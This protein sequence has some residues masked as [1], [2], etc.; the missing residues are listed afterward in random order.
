M[1]LLFK[2]T[3]KK[4]SIKTFFFPNWKNIF[5]QSKEIISI[6]KRFQQKKAVLI[7]VKFVH[8]SEIFGW[9]WN[10]WLML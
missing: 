5:N 8:M 2:Q 6:K 7:K 1:L 4:T 10:F 9:I 3:R